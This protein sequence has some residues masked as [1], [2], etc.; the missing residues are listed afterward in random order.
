MVNIKIAVVQMEVIA[1]RPDINSKK[2]IEKIKEAKK[3]KNDIVI[4]P[5]MAVGGYLLSDE[6]ENISFIKNLMD[7]NEKIKSE[8]K[9]ITVIWGNVFADF[10][11]KGEDGRVRKY[12]AALIASDGKWLDN[13]GFEGHT[14]KTL[15]PKY[16]EF[17]DERHFYS[18]QKLADE[19][20][21]NVDQI[22]KPFE[23]KIRD[24][25]IKLGLSLC[26]DMWDENYYLKPIE[27]LAKNGA[28]II[29]NIS[30]SP[31]TWQKNNKNSQ[32]LQRKCF[33]NSLL[34]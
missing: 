25:K 19:K 17:D 6:W 10:S 13:G 23:I 12:N 29:V 15:L 18:M 20:Q 33:E 27:I 16:R 14:F 34:Y 7:F 8:S 3:N 11:K 21:I 32:T 31:W 26:E 9:D 2:I 24:Q 4:F 1:G 28:E 30:A 22:L 5:E